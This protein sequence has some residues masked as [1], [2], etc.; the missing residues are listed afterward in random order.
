MQAVLPE[1]KKHVIVSNRNQCNFTTTLALTIII[2]ITIIIITITIIITT[3]TKKHV[4]ITIYH[5]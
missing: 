5:A 3:I 4:I 2:I 1:N